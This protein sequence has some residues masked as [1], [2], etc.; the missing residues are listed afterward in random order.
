MTDLSARRRAMAASKANPDPVAPTN[1]S[2]DPAQEYDRALLQSQHA[3]LRRRHHPGA[4]S[5]F[6]SGGAIGSSTI[7]PSVAGDASTSQSMG[8][9]QTA[10][11]GDSQ[12][13]IRPHGL[14][15]IHDDLP[16]EG[17][18]SG[19]D[20]GSYVDGDAKRAMSYEAHQEG[21]SE[22]EDLED[23]GVVGLLAQIYTAKGPKHVPAI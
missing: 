21:L 23:G 8:L 11:L 9:A 12:G 10:V 1:D 15:S 7:W 19:L 3:A 18:G 16:R 14:P 22:E 20:D 4:M 17:V 2:K 5:V 6:T 13:S